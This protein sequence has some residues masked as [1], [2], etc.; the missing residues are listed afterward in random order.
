MNNNEG[1]GQIPA[2]MEQGWAENMGLRNTEL[3]LSPDTIPY[4]QLRYVGSFTDP[5]DMKTNGGFKKN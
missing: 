3:G 5:A 2:L 4:L 1:Q